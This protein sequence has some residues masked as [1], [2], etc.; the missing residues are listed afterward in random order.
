MRWIVKRYRLPEFVP[1]DLRL[2]TFLKHDRKMAAARRSVGVLARSRRART[3]VHTSTRSRL[4]VL[5]VP[6]VSGGKCRQCARSFW[7]RFPGIHEKEPPSRSGAAAMVS[8]LLQP[9]GMIAARP[10]K[11]LSTRLAFSPGKPGET[12]SIYA[13]GFRSTSLPVVSGSVHE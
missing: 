3:A 12:I 8:M 11:P 6:Y 1:I 9:T 10:H 13:D 5:R 2:S 4:R 7:Q